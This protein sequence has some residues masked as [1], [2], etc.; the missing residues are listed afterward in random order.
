[1]LSIPLPTQG[2]ILSNNCP[3]LGVNPN[4]GVPFLVFNT[5]CVE[6]DRLVLKYNGLEV[7]ELALGD[8]P[9]EIDFN[10]ALD[11]N[12]DMAASVPDEPSEV[13]SVTA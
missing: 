6:K 13:E 3:A 2:A 7:S 11:I 8:T 10:G 5:L 1:M 12:I 4:T 9:V